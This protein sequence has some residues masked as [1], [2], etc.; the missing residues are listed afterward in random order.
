MLEDGIG[1]TRTRFNRV[2]RLTR[3]LA[4]LV[5]DVEATVSKSGFLTEV[6]V[7]FRPGHHREMQAG[8]RFTSQVDEYVNERVPER[9]SAR[10]KLG[11]E[12]EG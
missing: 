6:L 11:A 8:G 12:R 1:K 9:N 2:A 10:C 4:S 3:R 7:R 5:G